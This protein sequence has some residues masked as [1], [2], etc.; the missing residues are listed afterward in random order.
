MILLISKK[1]RLLLL[2][3]PL[4]II[5][6]GYLTATIF[7]SYI[8]EWAWVPL[9]LVYW[10]SLALCI[11]FFKSNK[12]VTDWLKKS[13]PSK[14]SISLAIIVG[15]FPMSILA[16]NYHLLDSTS[17]SYFGLALLLLI[18]GLKSYIGVD[19]Y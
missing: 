3:T 10:F 13:K 19:F 8:N 7:S 4:F 16:M 11:V 5:M 15:L 18:L 2:L 17:L 14:L 12:K 6:I 1:K 9:A